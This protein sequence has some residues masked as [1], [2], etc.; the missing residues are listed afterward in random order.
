MSDYKALKLLGALT[1]CAR[2][3]QRMLSAQ[4]KVAPI[5]PMDLNKYRILTDDEIVHI[6]QMIYRFSKMQDSIGE[7]LFKSVLVFLEEEIRNKPFLDVLNKLEQ[8]EILSNKDDWLRLRKL[9]NELAHEYSNED[10]ENTAVLNMLFGEIKTINSIFSGVKNY[11]EINISKKIDD[12]LKLQFRLDGSDHP[13][14]E[15]EN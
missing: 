5:F 12:K 14:E 13:R 1:E 2:H 8:L 10:E 15:K 3:S 6:D 11:Y 9:R 7:R 4:K